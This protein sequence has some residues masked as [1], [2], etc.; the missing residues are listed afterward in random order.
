MTN[1]PEPRGAEPLRLEA[2]QYY[3]SGVRRWP[4]TE[5]ILTT[6]GVL[7]VVDYL[8]PT[9][10][11]T[12]DQIVHPPEPFIP[13]PDE[14]PPIA[15]QIEQFEGR[16]EFAWVDAEYNGILCYRFGATPWRSI[17]H[18]PHRD[19]PPGKTPGLPALQPSDELPVA[20][21]LGEPIQCV[22]TVKWPESFV[23]AVRATVV[24]LIEQHFQARETLDEANFLYV[25][26]RSQ[27][28]ARRA[29]ARSVHPGR[30]PS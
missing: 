13:T 3:D 8:S 28:L 10:E 19:T 16:A 12:L 11:L 23:N 21:G 26:E 17:A 25:F 9:P 7:L 2:G 20:V 14:I 18:H 22:R 27:G 1:C 4:G 29:Q 5:L 15:Q 24:R 30:G 6:D